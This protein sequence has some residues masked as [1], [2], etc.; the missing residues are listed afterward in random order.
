LATAV[1]SLKIGQTPAD[2]RFFASGRILRCLRF[3]TMLPSSSLRRRRKALLFKTIVTFQDL[4]NYRKADDGMWKAEF[5]GA[6][7][8]A[9][10]GPTLE[11]CRS[12]AIHALDEKLSAW[13]IGSANPATPESD[14]Q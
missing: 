11:Q 13:I 3:T 5:H 10:E 9:T 7:D 12:R 14:D 2:V 1:A 6:L 8:I 4:L